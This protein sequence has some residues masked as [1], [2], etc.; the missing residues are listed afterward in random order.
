MLTL[1]VTVTD[2]VARKSTSV[3]QKFEVTAKDFGLVRI[4]VSGDP[5]N[6]IPIVAPAAGQP[7]WVHAAI[8]GF[9]RAKTGTKQPKIGVKLRVLDENGKPLVATPF[10]GTIDKDVPSNAN[11]LPVKFMVPLNRS[12]KYWVELSA[13]DGIQNNASVTTK[14]PITVSSA[15]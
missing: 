4:S 9:E 13:T 5:D 11:S 1:K 10:S 8:V 14:F 15:K 6:L 2:L 3:S 7:Y 12:G